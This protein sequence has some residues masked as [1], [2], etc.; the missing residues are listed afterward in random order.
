MS[1]LFNFVI[2]CAMQRPRVPHPACRIARPSG[3]W[4]GLR[5]FYS[6]ISREGNKKKKPSLKNDIDLDGAETLVVAPLK[7]TDVHQIAYFSLFDSL[8]RGKG[9]G[10]VMHSHVPDASALARPVHF[11]PSQQTPQMFLAQLALANLL[12]YAVAKFYLDTTSNLL[13]LMMAVA[14]VLTS[15]YA[16]AKVDLLSSFTSTEDKIYACVTGGLSF[17]AALVFLAFQPPAIFD[18]DTHTMAAALLPGVTELVRYTSPLH[19]VS[20]RREHV[21]HN[22]LTVMSS[23]W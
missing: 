14:C 23:C 2:L 4:V 22:K 19:N 20:S 10:E 9:Q 18:W 21:R 16:L 11:P 5:C 1:F 12:V 6:T 17:V 7:E 8:V 13:P 15:L 3:W